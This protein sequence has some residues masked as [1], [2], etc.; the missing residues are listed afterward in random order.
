[1]S[2]TDK[3]MPLFV[4]YSYGY[5]ER[6]H[7]DGRCEI[8]PAFTHGASNPAHWNTRRRLRKHTC[9][10]KVYIVECIHDKKRAELQANLDHARHR[11]TYKSSLLFRK[12]Y[13]KVFIHNEITGKSHHIPM[14]GL[15]AYSEKDVAK[16]YVPTPFHYMLA[17]GRMPDCD[18]ESTHTIDLRNYPF[19]FDGRMDIYSSPQTGADLLP[20][21]DE[22]IPCE[23][24]DLLETY[25]YACA[26][27]IEH[28]RSTYKCFCIACDRDRQQGHRKDRTAMRAYKHNV[29]KAFNSGASLD[30]IEDMGY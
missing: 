19:L 16:G 11:S 7:R 23:P 26:Y 24:C 3:D 5:I 6:D 22:T 13:P 30:E 28:Y 15:G 18:Q 4:K 20:A 27:E 12:T 17:Q 9:A 10:R 2:R 29:M 1:M 8:E 25:K 14:E 21:Y